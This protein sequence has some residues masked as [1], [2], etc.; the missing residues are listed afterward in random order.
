MEPNPHPTI[1]RTDTTMSNDT[2]TQTATPA[3]I[4]AWAQNRGLQV[5]ARGRI[6]AELRKRYAADSS[7]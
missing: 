3:E 7:R 6:S 5:G 1:H 2:S 4:R